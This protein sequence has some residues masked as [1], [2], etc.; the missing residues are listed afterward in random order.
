MKVEDLIKLTKSKKDYDFSQR[1]KMK[2]M[3]Y[4]EKC[5]LVKSVIENTSYVEQEG[6]RIY[7]RNTAGMLFVFTMQLISRYTDLEFE[8]ENV[9]VVY[10][11]LM[12][13]GIMNKL[14]AQIPEEEIS[15]LRGMLDMQRDDEEMNTRSLISFFETKADVARIFFEGL[16]KVLD[17]PEV[18]AKIAEMTK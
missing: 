18:Q 8:K 4:S 11:A 10:D 2:Y 9:V 3:P 17:K 12:E 15:I 13:S 7:K 6:K 16:N 5:A 14:M 1:I